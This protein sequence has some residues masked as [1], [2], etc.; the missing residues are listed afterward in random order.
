[1]HLFSQELAAL[2]QLLD[3]ADQLEVHRIIARFTFE[4]IS[5]YDQS[6]G[7]QDQPWQQNTETKVT[8]NFLIWLDMIMV[9]SSEHQDQ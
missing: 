6:Y 7:T 8:T 4:V 1:M 3:L 5:I 2:S 9:T